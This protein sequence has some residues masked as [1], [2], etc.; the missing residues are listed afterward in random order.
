MEIPGP[1]WSHHHYSSWVETHLYPRASH[2][3][4]H[5]TGRKQYELIL[6]QAGCLLNDHLV[7]FIALRLISLLYPLAYQRAVKHVAQGRIVLSAGRSA[8][9][10]SR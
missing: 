5:R 1:G 7:P 8:R 9:I 6:I 10:W 4:R 2:A 3:T